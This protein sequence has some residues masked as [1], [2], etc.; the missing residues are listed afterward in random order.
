MIEF[1]LIV[2]CKTLLFLLG[3]KLSASEPRVTLELNRQL[4]WGGVEHLSLRCLR[5]GKPCQVQ[6]RLS[7]GAISEKEIPRDQGIQALR[8]FMGALPVDGG[9]SPPSGRKPFPLL[10]WK[11]SRDGKKSEGE[12]FGSRRGKTELSDD[13]MWRAV[14]SVETKLLGWLS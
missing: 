13:R 6:Q 1:R 4:S 9:G 12:L 2:V 10:T 11:L 8:E 3:A 7:Q 5:P 14:L